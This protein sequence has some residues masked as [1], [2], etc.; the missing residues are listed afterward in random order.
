MALFTPT[1]RAALALGGGALL[2]SAAQAA[3]PMLGATAPTVRRIALGGFEVTTI[4]DGAITLG[5]PYPIFGEDQFEEDVQ[6]LAQ[7]NRL[8]V[9]QMAI[10]FTTT[11]VNTGAELILFDTGNGAGRRPNAGHMRERLAAA[12]YTPDQVDVVVLTHFHGDHIGG[13]VEDG[14]AAY[15]NARYV[16]TA[17]E[18][19]FWTSDAASGG[20]ADLVK[21]NVVPFA[22]KF[23]FIKPGDAVVSGVEAVDASGHTPGHAVFHVE[24]DGRRLMITADTANH[25]VVSL[26]RPDWHVRFDMD[27]QKAASARRNVFGMIAADAIPFIGYHMPFPAIGYVTEEGDGFRYAAESY[28]LSL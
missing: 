9:D 16:T 17:A 25:F 26:Q 5:G 1:R 20:T 8:P 19:D 27:K 11:L 14:E 18:Y 28:Q 12:G 23:T 3:A 6:E 4:H 15:P 22:E 7:A 13:M 10:S 21:T 24:S 2:G